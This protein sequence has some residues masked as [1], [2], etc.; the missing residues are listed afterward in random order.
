[1]D[2]FGMGMGEILL[3]LVIALIVLGP[4][5]VV[6]VG[7]TMGKA[8]RTLRK[9]SSDLTTQMSRELEGE[10]KDRSPHSGTSNGTKTKEPI[11]ADKA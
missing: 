8:A 1:M 7:R 9:V 3:I 2:F 10:E 4:G 11:D 6:Q 5:R